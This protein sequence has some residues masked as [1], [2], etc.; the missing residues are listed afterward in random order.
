VRVSNI[1]RAA[2]EIKDAFLY[3]YVLR[4]EP[5]GKLA[6]TWGV[7]KQNVLSQN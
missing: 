1:A 4:V 2:D 7:I 6:N 5:T 3:G